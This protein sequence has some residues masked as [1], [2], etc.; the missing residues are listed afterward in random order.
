MFTKINN[1]MYLKR[2]F[3]ILLKTIGGHLDLETYNN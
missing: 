2:N 1:N 3:E